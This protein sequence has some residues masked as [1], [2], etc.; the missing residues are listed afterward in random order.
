[1]GAP[2]ELKQGRECL[3]R[4][5]WEDAYRAFSHADQTGNL[6]GAD[7][8]GLAVSAYFI[9]RDVDCLEAL[10][11]AHRAYLDAGEN[12]RAVR[13][14]FWL[15][16]HL[17]L[18]G[19][20]SRATGWLAR[21]QRALKGRKRTCVEEGYLL[22]PVIEQQLNAEAWETAYANATVAV[23]MGDRF[24]EADL[25]ACARH[26]Q[27][28]ALIG[29]GRVVAGLKLLDETMVAVTAGELSPVITGLLYCSVIDTCWQVCSVGRAR[30]WTSALTQWCEDQHGMVAFTSTCLAHRAEIMQLHGAW[31]DAAEEAQRACDRFYQ[32]IDSQPPAAAVYQQA[33]VHRLRGEVADAERAYRS[34]NQWGRDPQPGL[35]QLRLIQGRTDTAVAAIRRAMSATTDRLQRARLLPAHIDIALAAADTKEARRASQ[36][37]GEIAKKVD[38]D[39]LHAMAAQATGAVELAQGNAEA[40]ISLLRPAWQMWHKL[41]VPYMGARVRV[42]IALA[43]RTLGDH[44]SSE[45][46]LDAARS[47]FEQLGAAPDIARIDSLRQSHRSPFRCSARVGGPSPAICRESQQGHRRR[48]DIERKDSGPTREQYLQQA[49]RTI[50]DRCRGLRLRAQAALILFQAIGGITHGGSAQIG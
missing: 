25:I 37:L 1:M 47:T 19:N 3:Q 44:D 15:G 36:E 24:T 8:E 4:L 12:L 5:A 45:M 28:R 17:V 43:C 7:L 48:A 46:E 49:R 50:T 11:R 23:K 39:M 41:Q 13:C 33:E 2:N 32:G 22:L 21:G 31:Q 10:N 35:A 30:E 40:A 6:K 18:R 29:L 9:G 14:A 27:G 20:I 26:L 38:T 16:L 34:A 42:L